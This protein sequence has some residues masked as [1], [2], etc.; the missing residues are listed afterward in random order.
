MKPT[1]IEA[2][3]RLELFG[4]ITAIGEPD[5]C[6]NPASPD[7]N[8]LAGHTFA[9]DSALLDDRCPAVREKQPMD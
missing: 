1:S 6:Q 3:F 2:A 4:Q 7:G 8:F 9:T 5:R